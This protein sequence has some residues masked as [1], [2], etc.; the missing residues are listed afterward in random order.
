MQEKHFMN[1]MQT[2]VL[3]MHLLNVTS[4]L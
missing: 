2:R 1:N 4:W 3:T